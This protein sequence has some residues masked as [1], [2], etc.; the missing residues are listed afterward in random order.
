MSRFWTYAHQ[1]LGEAPFVDGTSI[2]RPV[3]PLI[4]SN[5]LPVL[6]EV[7]TARILD[8][9]PVTRRSSGF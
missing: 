8:S 4:V 1:D 9:S 5:E 2:L 7:G 3:V 6:E